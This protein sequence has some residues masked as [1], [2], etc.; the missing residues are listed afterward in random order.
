MVTTLYRTVKRRKIVHQE[1]LCAS[2][3]A[4]YCLQLRSRAILLENGKPTGGGWN[5]DQENRRPYDGQVAISNRNIL[6]MKEG[7]VLCFLF[8]VQTATVVRHGCVQTL[9]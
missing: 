5:F 1:L 8:F 3:P 6:S 7:Q 2:T 9:K 4:G